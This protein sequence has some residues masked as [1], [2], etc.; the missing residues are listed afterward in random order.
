MKLAR[1]TPGTCSGENATAAGDL[2]VVAL[3][4]VRLARVLRGLGRTVDARSQVDS[5]RR[6]F[7]TAGGGDGALLADH[8]AAELAADPERLAA[9]LAAA[10]TAGDPEVEVLTLDALARLH[11]AAGRVDEAA[12]LRAAADDLMPAAGHLLTADDRRP[13]PT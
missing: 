6:W 13:P 8:L 9:V 2:R 11:A 1:S 10:R 3:A 5:A 4:R 12:E 7:A